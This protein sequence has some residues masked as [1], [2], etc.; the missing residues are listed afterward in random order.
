M[1][2]ITL[3]RPTWAEI[4]LD[5]LAA[6]YLSVRH[7][8][9]EGI[10]CMAVI[11]A[12]AYGHGAVECGRRLEQE[13]AEWLAVATV[14]EGVEL[15]TAGI[16]PPILVLGGFWPGQIGIALAE[17]LT[18]VIFTIE[19]A[20]AIDGIAR[21]GGEA[22]SVHIKFDTGMGRL[23][24]RYDEAP[25]IAARL[26]EFSGIRIEGLMTHFAAA[27]DLASDLTAIQISRFE[28]IKSAFRAA[29]IEPRYTDLANSPGAVAHPNSRSNLV[30]LGGVFYGLGG[31]V[32]PKGIE[33]PQLKAVMSVRSRIATIKT[34]KVGQS[35]GYSRTFTAER[36]T[37]VATVPIGYHDGFRRSLSNVGKVIVRGQY[38]DV[39]GRVSMD[40]ITIDVT[41]VPEATVGDLV[42]VIGRDV[43]AEIKAEDISRELGTISYEVTCGI[44]RRVPRLFSGKNRL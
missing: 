41:D 10:E 26:S 23:G 42:T 14:E 1:E 40:W 13:G 11:K 4:N 9:G 43:S 24:F 22:V 27:D 2:T 39:I 5:D 30:R 32:L 15:R 8:V 37:V 6:N 34:I 38:T 19:Q 20:E 33:T 35:V 12:D 16:S 7:F 18:P 29:G 36:D 21:S 44:S 25:E 28:D 31:D 17:R 3:Q